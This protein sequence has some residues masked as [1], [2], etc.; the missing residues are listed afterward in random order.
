[1]T[2]ARPTWLLA[3]LLAGCGTSPVGTGIDLPTIVAVSA[4]DFR[5][6]VPCETAPGAM[7]SFVATLTDLG[8]TEEPVTFSLPS[9]VVRSDALG[10]RFAPIACQQAAGFSFVVPGH[11][12]SAEIEA[13]DRTD[14]V[15]LG[16]GSRV[17]VDPA[18]GNYVPPRWTTSCGTK[19]DVP[20]EGP[21][22][23]ALYRT[24]YVRG[25]GP[26]Q[27]AFGTETAIRI[28]TTNAAGPECGSG[29]GEVES[30]EATLLETGA[31]QSGACGEAI[32]FGG[33][34]GAETYHFE[35]FGYEAGKLLPTWGTSCFRT[36]LSGAIVDAGCGSLLASG[37]MEVETTGVV[38]SL[39]ESCG[40]GDIVS[41]AGD[42]IATGNPKSVPC[43]ATIR[44]DGLEPM[45]YAVHVTTRRADGSEGPTAICDAV[46]VPGIARRATC[47]PE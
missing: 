40:P 37:S 34:D 2:S 19:S 27:E 21:V 18:S 16:P 12:Y 30:F 44:F 46:V 33:L 11:R 14:L 25:C 41:V 24:R 42:I 8:T 28:D 7:R 35:L 38:A 29:P 9:S 23:A 39:G 15:A 31:V 3:A 6:A 47:R 10:G 1:M 20:G 13:Y 5:G 4:E 26:L 43:G 32:L 45:S 36:A 22:T 17:L